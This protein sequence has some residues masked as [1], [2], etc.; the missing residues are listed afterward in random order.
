MHD[1]DIM[2]VP[3]STAAVRRFHVDT[4]DVGTIGGQ[5]GTVLAEVMTELTTAGISPDGPPLAS[6][7]MT[8][9]GFDVAAGFRVPPGVDVPG[10]DI[11]ALGAAEVAHTTHVGPYGDLPAAYEDLQAGVRAQGRAVDYH[12]PMW[13]EYWSPPE[14][15]ADLTR[16]EIYWPITESD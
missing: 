15:P 13:E 10:T 9:T 6:Y 14:T 5:V 1:I 8:T 4:E 16:T 12:G 11:M 7:E 3:G 2:K